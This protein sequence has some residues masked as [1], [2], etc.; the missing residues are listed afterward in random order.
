MRPN[1]YITSQNYVKTIEILQHLRSNW[2][3]F[4][5][6]NGSLKH[7]TLK[8]IS[9]FVDTLFIKEKSAYRRVIWDYTNSGNI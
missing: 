8:R 3:V 4:L 6:Y 1:R 5:F 7:N 2:H 9:L